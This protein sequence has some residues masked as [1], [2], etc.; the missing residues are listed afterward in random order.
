MRKWGAKV[1]LYNKVIDLQ[2][3]AQAWNEV[4]KNRPAAG[5]D[6][7]TFEQFEEGKAEKI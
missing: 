6:N 7:V 1:S 3:L 5:V 2:K 4:K